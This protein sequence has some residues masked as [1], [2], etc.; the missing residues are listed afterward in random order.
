MNTGTL[1][2]ASLSTAQ[3]ADLL[4][5]GTL[6]QTFDNGLSVVVVPLQS[7]LV[8]LQVWA[9]VG[10]RH[11]VLP[12]TTGYAHFFE[13]LMF[14]GSAAFS[15]AAREDE[16]VLRGLTGER[17]VASSGKLALLDRLLLDRLSEKGG[18]TLSDLSEDLPMTRRAMVNR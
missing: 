11:E 14:R 8:A 13:H 10:S 18:L 16:A 15:A 4:P 2:W 17:L 1:L 3:G 9:D 7:E 12:G 6:Q 5:E